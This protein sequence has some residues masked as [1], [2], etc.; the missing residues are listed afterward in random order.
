MADRIYSK[1][2]SACWDCP[3]ST[4]DDELTPVCAIAMMV[5]DLRGNEFLP[6]WCPLP[7]ADDKGGG[8]E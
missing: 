6:D 8:D 5:L 1:R 7:L 3:H 4:C 2:V